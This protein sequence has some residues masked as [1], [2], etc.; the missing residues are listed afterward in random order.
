MNDK[1]ITELVNKINELKKQCEKIKIKSLLNKHTDNC[2][3][4][5]EIHA[6]A[7][8][9]ESQDWAEMLSR[10]YQRFAEKND[11]KFKIIDYQRGE[12]AGIK[13][14]SM[15]I[16]GFKSYGYLK[17]ESGIHRLVRISPFDSNKRRHTSFSSVWVYPEIDKDIDIDINNKD[18]R[19]DTFRASGAGGQHINTTDS[20]VRITH[21]KYNI[22]V[23]SQSERS[24]HRNRDTAMKM[25]KSRLYEIELDKKNEEKKKVEGNKKKIGWGN[26][27]RSYVLHPYKMVKDLRTNYQTSKAENVLDGEIIDFLESTLID[28]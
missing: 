10:M 6:G 25:L 20:A 28:V 15:N 17:N 24:Q 1:E 5:L 16:M 8:G 4:F 3:A 2:N 13:S 19:I 21:L 18:L 12:E 14:V 23:Q 11:Y 27:I 22:V 7:G 9:T 26:Q